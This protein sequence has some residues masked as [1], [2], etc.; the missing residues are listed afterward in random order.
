MITYLP[1]IDKETSQPSIHITEKPDTLAHREFFTLLANSFTVPLDVFS[2]YIRGPCESINQEIDL[3]FLAGLL[4]KTDI[5]KLLLEQTTITRELEI[6]STNTLMENYEKFSLESKMQFPYTVSLYSNNYISTFLNNLKNIISNLNYCAFVS[7]SKSEIDSILKSSKDIIGYELWL[8]DDVYSAYNL[9]NAYLDDL[10]GLTLSPFTVSKFLLD[11]YRRDH[12]KLANNPFGSPGAYIACLLT[13][14]KYKIN[15]LKNIKDIL[16]PERSLLYGKLLE[17]GYEA[18]QKSVMTYRG[19]EIITLFLFCQYIVYFIVEFSIRFSQELY[20]VAYFIHSSYINKDYS[21][22]QVFIPYTV[23]EIFRLCNVDGEDL[24]HSKEAQS[25]DQ[26]NPQA[27]NINPNKIDENYKNKWLKL[28]KAYVKIFKVGISKIFSKGNSLFFKKYYGR[29]PH[30]FK[31]YGGEA[32]VVENTMVADPGQILSGSAV[33]YVERMSNDSTK[34]FQELLSLI[35]RLTSISN[36]KEKITAVKGFCK[37]FKFDED[38]PGSI[39]EA[40]LS[41][42]RYRIAASILQDNEIYGFTVDGIMQNR[43]FPPANHIVTSLFVRNPHEKPLEQ[44]VADIFS[45]DKNILLF[46]H[47]E[48]IAKFNNLYQN[49]ASK[50]IETFNPKVASMAEKNIEKAGKRFSYQLMHSTTDDLNL[51]GEVDP[52][53]QKKVSEKIDRAVVQ[54]IDMAIA[55]KRRCLQCAGIAHDMIGR[56]TDLAKRCVVSMLNVEKERTDTTKNQKGTYYNSGNKVPQG[57]R[58]INKQLEANKRHVENN[59][60]NPY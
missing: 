21:D 49:S 31:Q 14:Y 18:L 59:N 29:I 24:S 2:T 40:I 43:K 35:K 54:A 48:Q 55:Q 6:D 51:Q 20:D 11:Q 3:V 12:L 30:L 25:I 23:H 52:K 38:N 60:N 41:Q 50:I 27:S 53:E 34:L 47:P 5:K 39:K 10:M 16:N 58:A 15:S 9:E 1:S 37:K 22:S 42:T 33:K 32:T 36:L 17:G 46:A 57:N 45:D 19:D 8:H 26:L 28:Q 4:Q 7:G 13:P 44:R 56:V